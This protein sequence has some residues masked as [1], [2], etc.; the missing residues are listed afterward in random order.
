M[1]RVWYQAD[2]LGES[3]DGYVCER[4][5]LSIKAAIPGEVC[6]YSVWGWVSVVECGCE[7]VGVWARGCD[8][9]QERRSI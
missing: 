4:V 7:H 2:L 3:E 1:G 8:G 9:R 6:V 5:H